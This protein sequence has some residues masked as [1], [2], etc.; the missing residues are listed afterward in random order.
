[1]L[2]KVFRIVGFTVLFIFLLVFGAA[3]AAYLMRNQLIQLFVNEA[4]KSIATEIFVDK[5]SLDFIHTFPQFAIE[6]KGV[7]IIESIPKSK[8]AFAT[9]EKLYFSFSIW[10][11]LE[12]KYKI[13]NLYL[14]NAKLNFQILENGKNNFSIIKQQAASIDKVQILFN[15]KGVKL[16]NVDISYND[17]PLKNTFGAIFYNADANFKLIDQDW[18]ISVKGILQMHQI[19][20]N[21]WSFFKDKPATIESKIFYSSK[22]KTYKIFPSRLNVINAKFNIQGKYIDGK[23]P[24]I[25]LQF[26]EQNS[27]FQ[28]II[29]FLPPKISDY[30]LTY[31]SKGKVYFN[32]IVKGE[33]SRTEKTHIKVAF[34]C[35]NASFFHPEYN[36]GVENVS[37]KGTFDNE[38]ETEKTGVFKLE[39]IRAMMN[40]R[41]FEGNFYQRSFYN[42]YIELNAKSSVDAGYF[43]KIFPN[44]EIET[45]KGDIDFDVDFKGNMADL[46]AKKYDL[47]H[48]TGNIQV[49][50]LELKLKAYQLGIKQ[51]NG[52]FSFTKTDLH[53]NSFSMALG[54][55][56]IKASGSIGNIFPYLLYKNQVLDIKAKIE[57]EH[58]NLD[59]LFS[60]S[61][62]TKDAKYKF[63]ISDKLS[64]DIEAKIQ[65]LA[66]QKFKPKNVKGSLSLRNQLITATEMTMNIANG[67][68]FLDGTVVQKRDT[69][70]ETDVKFKLDKM[71]IDSIYEMTDNFGQDFITYQNLRGEITSDVKTLFVFDKYLN[72]KPES[73]VAEVNTSIKNGQ[74]V[75]FA[76]MKNLAKFV[77]EDALANIR[78]LELKNTIQIAKQIVYIPEMEIASNINK[79]SVLGSHSF[80]NEFEYRFKIPLK[81]Y[82]KKDNLEEE[83]AIE[84]NIFSGFYL[85]LIIKGT[86]ANFKILYDKSAVKQKIK[87]RWQEEKKEIK[88]IFRKDYQKKQ[89]E[90]QKAVEINDDEYL[91]L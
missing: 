61:K 32:G 1:M 37:F 38:A 3:T 53:A 29:S 65:S 39:N 44:Q 10:D 77:N 64:F 2:K 55:S 36:A 11:L 24:F 90:K 85:Y 72:I 13:K 88:E 69:T 63:E 5:I 47:L 78:F 82:K 40:G 43:L 84:G 80:G 51:L 31:K 46:K 50:N 7:K 79:M 68:L 75:N 54:K 76:P 34:G 81:N 49:R 28:T 9:A 42:P 12:R 74:L 22:D 58:M 35:E 14:K 83:Q 41:T 27:D 45:A 56:D 19:K 20:L 18:D 17:V 6:F 33:I 52:D 60:T 26:S 15:L 59:E 57:S 73:I 87:E 71:Q 66:F 62:N 91:D 4:N 8:K 16:E 25:D 30:L 48:T 67:K 23:K 89:Q 86:P 21:T 70:F